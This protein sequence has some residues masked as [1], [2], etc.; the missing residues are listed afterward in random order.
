MSWRFRRSFKV[1]PGLKL[2][3]S[4]SGLSLSIGGAP[5]TLNVGRKGAYTTSSIP[6]TG[7]SF[8]QRVSGKSDASR[9]WPP[10]PVITR[11]LPQ[12]PRPELHSSRPGGPIQEIRSASSDILTSKSLVDLKELIQT[13]HEEREGIRADLIRAKDQE[14][15]A[16]P[17]YLSWEQG[18]LLKRLL[19][20]SFLRRKEM[21]DMA[22]AKIEELEE[23]LQL[24]SVNTFAELSDEQSQRYIRMRDDFSK[25]AGCGAIWDLT[26]QETVDNARERTSVGVRIS[27]KLVKFSLGSSEL[28][29][30][31]QEVPH[32]ENA[33]GGD[34][35]LYPGF[36]LYRGP[37]NA[38]AVI[39]YH[40]LEVTAVGFRC[41][42]DEEVPSDAKIVGRT[43][44]KVNKDGTPDRRFVNNREIPIAFYG[45]LTLKT[46]AGL[47]ESYQFSN[48][49]A[50]E[51]FVTSWRDFVMCFDNQTSCVQLNEETGD[52]PGRALGPSVDSVAND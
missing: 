23:Q 37:E 31:E 7:L 22:S 14:D 24:T 28:I 6:G 27:R 18:W 33:N 45:E 34:L 17:R 40:D 20:K 49:E 4:K 46:E 36:I 52:Q 11:V 15:G 42:S 8:R 38:F 26:S 16:R 29:Q 25:L 48:P 32:L 9:S 43:W 10:S 50:L 51:R 13:T 12:V 47:W 1:I 2:N 21:A 30:W 35:Y 44:V 3:L 19:R 5:F 41:Q 39:A